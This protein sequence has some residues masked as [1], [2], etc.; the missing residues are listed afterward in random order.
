M[1]TLSQNW[2]IGN[3]KSANA[4]INHVK[5]NHDVQGLTSERTVTKC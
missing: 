5:I 2:V 3:E 1:Q 4:N